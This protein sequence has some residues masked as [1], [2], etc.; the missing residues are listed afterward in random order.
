MEK[1]IEFK[2]GSRKPYY[3][4]RIT[5]KTQLQKPDDL[6]TIVATNGNGMILQSSTMNTPYYYDFNTKTSQW[7]FPTTRGGA[8]RQ[9]IREYKSTAII[10]LTTHLDEQ[11][12]SF[13]D[14]TQR[15]KEFNAFGARDIYDNRLKYQPTHLTSCTVPDTNIDDILRNIIR[16]NP[17]RVLSININDCIIT[18]MNLLANFPNLRAL[19]CVNESLTLNIL[20]DIIWVSR[21]LTQLILSTNIGDNMLIPIGLLS[22]LQILDISNCGITGDTLENL[23]RLTNL[24][25]LEISDNELTNISGLKNINSLTELQM[26]GCNITADMVDSSLI[27]LTNLTSLAISGN[28]IGDIGLYSIVTN[29]P[30]L[31]YLDISHNGIT[32]SGARYIAQYLPN[33]KEL[34]LDDDITQEGIDLLQ[35]MTHADKF[36][37]QLPIDI[38]DM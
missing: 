33:L 5:G 18:D 12:V 6:N 20:I 19:I 38:D 35:R 1:W 13:S 9:R 27:S 7:S 11:P 31:E 22:K 36:Y 23:Q 15:W 21:Q 2:S 16:I 3:Y 4:N 30:K 14:Y 25:T 26:N 17:S 10:P 29:L 34:V 32:I 24:T 28:E 8:K 37:L